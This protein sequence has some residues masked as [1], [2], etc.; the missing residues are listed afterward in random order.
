MTSAPLRLSV[1]GHPIG[2]SLSPRMHG[3]ALEALGVR[4]TYEARDVLAHELPAVFDALR[5]GGL[6]GVNVTL[7][8]KVVAAR[9]CDRLE[10]D[11][12]ETG[13]VNTLVREERGLVGANTDVEGLL[14][15]LSP[16]AQELRGRRVVILGAGGAA[17]AALVAARR[18]LAS[19]VIVAARDRAKGLALHD[20]AVSLGERAALTRAFEGAALLVQASSATLGEGADA[21]ARSLPL[22]ALG[23]DA[24]VMDLVYRPRRTSVLRAA[25]ARGLRTLDG[26]ELLVRQGAAALARWLGRD[27]ES[28]PIDAMRDAVVR[29][30]LADDARP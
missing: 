17:R 10:E 30:L 22:E 6:D 24:L 14:R 28:M 27:A 12:R 29:A 11:A 13:A 16:H 21:F 3:A 19:E 8:Y 25:E 5:G 18:L 20:R 7:P 4:G 2:H 23:G 9:A 1:V 15:A 26:V